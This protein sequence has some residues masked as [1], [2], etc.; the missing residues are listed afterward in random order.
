MN[1]L[2]NFHTLGVGRWVDDKIVNFLVK[3]WCLESG[4]T[5]GFSTFFAGK[6]LFQEGD[7][8]N[9]KPKVTGADKMCLRGFYRDA[10]KG[11][12]NWDRVFIPINEGRMHWYS[13]RIDFHL[14]RIDIFDS[15]ED[16]YMIVNR[17][18]PVLLQKN[19]KLMMLSAEQL[20][21]RSTSAMAPSPCI[22]V[23]PNKAAQREWGTTPRSSRI[24]GQYGR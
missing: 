15:L 14:K 11:I 8:V 13:A 6:V 1:K 16:R 23:L 20:Q 4:T 17:K 18:K 2:R 7:C 5:I 24:Y 19:A 21:L 3:K 22:G 12:P 9:P 10:V